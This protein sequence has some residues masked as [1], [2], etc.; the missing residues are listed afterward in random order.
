MIKGETV[1]VRTFTEG[2]ADPFENAAKVATEETVEDVLVQVGST[3]DLTGSIRPDGVE[4]KF[5]L[6][7]P[8]TYNVELRGAQVQVRGSWYGVVGNPAWYTADNCPTK[9]NYPVEV[10]ATNG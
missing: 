3:S 8:K 10:S 2:E 1:V 7:F 5:T 9:W 4:V 6:H